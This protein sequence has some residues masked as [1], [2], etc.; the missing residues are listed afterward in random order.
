MTFREWFERCWQ[1]SGETVTTGLQR[2]SARQGI[3]YKT[4]FYA[5]KGCRVTPGTAER[6]EEFSAGQVLAADL[7]ML[8]TRA[9]MGVGSDLPPAGPA[10]TARTG[11]EG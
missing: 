5:H 9:E 3:S 11:T 4:L 8:P 10:R 7:V 1:A 2:L 6:I